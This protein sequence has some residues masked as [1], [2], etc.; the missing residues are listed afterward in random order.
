MD[1]DLESNALASQA[2]KQVIRED[3]NRAQTEKEVLRQDLREARNKIPRGTKLDSL[4]ADIQGLTFSMEHD[5]LSVTEEKRVQQ[6]LAALTAARP[7]AA[8]ITAQEDKL[9]SVEERRAAAKAR[10]DECDAV[11]AAIKEKEQVEVAALDALHKKQEET[12]LDWPALNVEKQEAWEVIQ[13][14]K[15]K[16]SEIRDDFNKKYQ[17]WKKLNENYNA[18]SRHDKKAQ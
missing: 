8:Q 3:F 13:A 2:Q 7:L 17:D 5:S 4:E 11:L 16:I 10:L 14:L 12:N 15:A 9:K 6:Q 1:Q 18:W